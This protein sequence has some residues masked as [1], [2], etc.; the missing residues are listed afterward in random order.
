MR[1]SYTFIFES[2]QAE[3]FDL[4]FDSDSWES[5]DHLPGEP[6]DWTLL[7]NNRCPHCTVDA[8]WKPYCPLAVRIHDVV[9]RFGE[10]ISHESVMVEVK[11]A[12]RTCIK[13][14]SAQR[15]VS[16][17]LGVIIP[18]SG[19]PHTT[20]LRPMAR[21]HL[22][23]ST[24]EETVYRAISMYLLGQFFAHRAGQKHV[25]IQLNGLKEYYRNLEKVNV[26]LARRIR[27]VSTAD[28]SINA[29]ILLDFFAKTVSCVIEDNLEGLRK[30]FASY[31]GR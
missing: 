27:S 11:A 31:E 29:V 8:G 20:F 13:K 21:F 14:T 1:I 22:P 5:T 25:D 4:E 2:G 24:E 28:S 17:L 15:G 7:D 30:L 10:R 3:K 26:S 16:S 18:A 12:G 23:F 9:D 19:C 6:P